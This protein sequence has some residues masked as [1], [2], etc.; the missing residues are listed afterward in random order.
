[1]YFFFVSSCLRGLP[2]FVPWTS[3]IASPARIASAKLWGAAAVA[4]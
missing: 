3:G 1:M 4:V 2:F